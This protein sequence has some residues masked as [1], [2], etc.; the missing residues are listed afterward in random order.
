MHWIKA[1]PFLFALVGIFILILLGA[2]LVWDKVATAPSFSAGYTW[3]KYGSGRFSDII[4]N[5]GSLRVP[6]ALEKEFSEE[7]FYTLLSETRDKPYTSLIPQTNVYES[8]LNATGTISNTEI[9]FD[10]DEI[11]ALLASISPTAQVVTPY[12]PFEGEFL[13]SDIYAFVPATVAAEALESSKL[14][15]RQRALKDYG[16]EAGSYIESFN[17]R[18]RDQAQILKQFLEDMQNEEK[19][20]LVEDL[21]FALTRIGRDL[22]DIDIIPDV[23]QGVN[24]RLASGYVSIGEKL[25]AVAQARSDEALLDAILAY[26]EA[27]DDFAE[28]YLS[29]VTLLSVAEVPFSNSE[30][31]SVFVFTPSLTI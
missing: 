11:T 24:A 14:T 23:A 15:E 4:A 26:N 7:D 10:A 2:I 29:T 3:G 21:A 17:E 20:Q 25:T 18:W 13:L 9:T 6:N 31:G 1:H 12:N 5:E 22:A 28:D 19:A 27:A 8:R 30:P 16:N